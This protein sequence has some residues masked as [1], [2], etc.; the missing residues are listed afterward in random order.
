MIQLQRRPKK[1]DGENMTKATHGQ[2]DIPDPITQGDVDGWLARLRNFLVCERKKI[3]PQGKKS[4]PRHTPSSHSQAAEEEL[5]EAKIRC[6][7]AGL[8]Q[9]LVNVSRW[10][11]LR[12]A[13]VITTTP[14][15][16]RACEKLVGESE[17]GAVFDYCCHLTEY[18]YRYWC[19]EEADINFQF[20]I[21]YW[22]WIKTSVPSTRMHEFRDY[23]IPEDNQYW[24]L[25]H[26]LNGLG[27]HD[28]ADCQVYRWDG[29]ATSLLADHFHEG[30]PSV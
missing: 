27:D 17:L 5:L 16:I 10:N 1:S 8:E 21:N 30:V 28:Y 29:T 7:L 11:A 6:W 3:R 13:V 14:V 4:P 2:Q 22:A 18:E 20:H 24:L 23:P 9:R 26:G 15:G 25:R 19:K 12:P